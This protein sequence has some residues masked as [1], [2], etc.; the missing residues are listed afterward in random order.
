MK[1]NINRNT[2]S[3][4]LLIDRYEKNKST[5]TGSIINCCV[6][7]K[8]FTKKQYSQA[9]CGNKQDTKCKDKFWNTVD[10]KKYNNTTRIS[11]ANARYYNDV[12]LPREASKR[13][14]PD[15][16]TMQNDFEDHEKY[17]EFCT[18]CDLRYE[19]CRCDQ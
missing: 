17:V 12:I 15:V 8:E 10:K 9:F 3:I 6:C 14:Y 7:L 11:K 19:Y 5:K 2:K 13:G 4:K 18:C 1:K 16:E